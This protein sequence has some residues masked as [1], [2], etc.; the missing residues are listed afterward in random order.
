MNNQSRDAILI[1]IV[2]MVGISTGIMIYYFA[3][4]MFLSALDL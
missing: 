3:L 1:A 2:I 4:D